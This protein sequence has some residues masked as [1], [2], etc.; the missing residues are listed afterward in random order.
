[1]APPRQ[2]LLNVNSLPLFLEELD[3]RQIKNT[4]TQRKQVSFLHTRL[5]VVLVFG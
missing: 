5:R 3:E 2:A 1:M 4:S